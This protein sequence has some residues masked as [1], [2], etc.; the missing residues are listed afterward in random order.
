[1]G[2]ECG[3]VNC[4]WS[5]SDGFSALGGLGLRRGLEDCLIGGCCNCFGEFCEKSYQES[6]VGLV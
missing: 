5:G 4:W 2:W 3:S 6:L 1:M